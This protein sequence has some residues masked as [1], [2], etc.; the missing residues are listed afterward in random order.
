MSLRKWRII[1]VIV[2]VSGF[3][4]MFV[5]A[6]NATSSHKEAFAKKYP[7]AKNLAECRLCHTDTFGFNAY[8]KDFKNAGHN[9]QAIENKD[10]DGDGATNI[11][12]I[13]SGTW[14]GNATSRPAGSTLPRPPVGIEPGAGIFKP[15]FRQ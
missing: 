4:L 14:P 15:D 6:A 2:L 8:G 1:P 5:V 7:K 9:F 3:W 12:E 10:S 13:S 11:E